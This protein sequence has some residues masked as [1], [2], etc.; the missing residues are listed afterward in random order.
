MAD[1]TDEY[2]LPVGYL[3][4]TRSMKHIVPM[5]GAEHAMVECF[6]HPDIT[7]ANQTAALM[8]LDELGVQSA[9]PG[10]LIFR[11]HAAAPFTSTEIRLEADEEDD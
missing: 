2:G 11:H 4:S 5:D 10:E 1:E 6:C 3:G 8:G 7:E 9:E